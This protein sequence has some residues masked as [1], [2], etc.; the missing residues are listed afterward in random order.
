MIL[1][2]SVYTFRSLELYILISGSQ[3]YHDLHFIDFGSNPI[4]MYLRLTH[5]LYKGTC[6]WF[7]PLTV[8]NG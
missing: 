6:N 4:L 5:P 7:G 1:V 8:I 2:I 3:G